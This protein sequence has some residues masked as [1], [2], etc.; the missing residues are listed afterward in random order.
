MSETWIQPPE[1]T[2]ASLRHGIVN[3]DGIEF[4]L[5]MT[6]DKQLVIHHDAKISVNKSLL[7]KSNP[8]VESWDSTEL[9][10][11]GFSTLDD[12]LNDKEIISQWRDNGKMVC[13]ELKRPHPKSPIGGGYFGK[14]QVTKVISEMITK[15]ELML[16]EA[17]IPKANSVFYAFHN[18]M[19][20]SVKQVNCQR[21]WA[22]LLPV[23]PR[24]GTKRFKRIMAYPQYLI[25]PFSRLINKHR[26]REASMVP[27]AIEY[28]QPFYNRLLI[29]KSVGLSGKRLNHFRNCQSGV[30]VYVW[31]A[32][33][34]YEHKLLSSGITGLTD[35]L[36]PN[37]TMYQNGGARWTFP[38]TK[39][40]DEQQLKLLDEATWETHNDIL[41]QLNL[42]A[43]NWHECDKS[44]RTQLIK[45][46]ARKWNW[47]INIESTVNKCTLSPPWQSVRLIG[48][49]GSGKTARPIINKTS[50]SMS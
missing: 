49:R 1:N 11:L 26:K 12:I 24:Y 50:F 15:A 7:E 47:D 4:D 3:S 5:R 13:L 46:W 42:D 37:F 28:F 17:E 20:K 41:K 2:L 22:E 9:K 25:T 43:P 6:S 19:H 40:L 16:D 38:A 44:R 33:E 31:P 23:V 27:C 35:N 39:P 14:K 34:K 21:N 8:Y 48:H 29:G 10:K 18:Q 45:M 32:L 30:P 36:D